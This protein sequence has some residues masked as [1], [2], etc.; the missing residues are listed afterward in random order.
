MSLI[1]GTTKDSSSA[2]SIHHALVSG[3][4]VH[5]SKAVTLKSDGTNGTSRTDS[6]GNTI[7][8]CG[9]NST[10]TFANSSSFDYG[11]TAIRVAGSSQTKGYG[12]STPDSADW[13]FTSSD[14]TI[15]GWIYVDAGYM[16]SGQ[17][18][19]LV[20]QSI[21]SDGNWKFH[22]TLNEQVAFG[23]E[24]VSQTVSGTGVVNECTWHH[25]HMTWDDSTG[26]IKIFT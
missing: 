2:N 23:K 21:T 16:G 11:N 17:Y 25:M 5:H 22:L 7:Y 15:C 3:G 6:N 12:L 4:G 20:G 26:I 9:S 13:D 8:W 14:A 18:P 10:V 1:V 24:G 19:P